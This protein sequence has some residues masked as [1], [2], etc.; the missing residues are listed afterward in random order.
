MIDYEKIGKKIPLEDAM[1][2]CRDCI[3]KIDES[4][5]ENCFPVCVAQ[6]PDRRQGIVVTSPEEIPKGWDQVMCN[7]MFLAPPGSLLL[8][9]KR[10]SS[11]EEIEH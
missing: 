7:G 11:S 2:L 1:Q 4:P 8:K 10:C 9:V 5:I 6:S 3:R